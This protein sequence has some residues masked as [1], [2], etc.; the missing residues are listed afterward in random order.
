MKGSPAAGWV[1]DRPGPRPQPPHEAQCVRRLRLRRPD[2]NW[3]GIADPVGMA[4][5]QPRVTEFDWQPTIDMHD[6]K[7]GNQTIC[8]RLG[9]DHNPA[10]VSGEEPGSGGAHL[11]RH[12]DQRPA[13]RGPSGV[14]GRRWVG[15][16]AERPKKAPGRLQAGSELGLKGKEECPGVGAVPGTPDCRQ[17]RLMTT[18]FYRILPANEPVYRDSSHCFATECEGLQSGT[19]R[20]KCW[21][22]RRF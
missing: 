12:A 5:I 11:L 9:L 1:G 20:L 18:G 17:R 19:D 14:L 8:G 2:R 21:K 15:R 22:I 3:R 10:N 7:A 13:W 4:V 6:S 16:L